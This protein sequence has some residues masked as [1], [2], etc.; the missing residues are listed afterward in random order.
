[1]CQKVQH[2]FRRRVGNSRFGHGIS[3]Q[4]RKMVTRDSSTF[5]TCQG[6]L[7]QESSKTAA[8]LLKKGPSAKGAKSTLGSDFRVGKSETRLPVNRDFLDKY[9][10][11]RP[12]PSSS[13]RPT[14]KGGAMT[15]RM[16]A[17]PKHNAV[18]SGNIIYLHGI[19]GCARV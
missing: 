4:N 19:S 5:E 9:R 1:M 2:F 13:C 12:Y 16:P 10:R 17:I 15:W 14:S 8:T 7:G 3:C 18:Y 6:F 11:P